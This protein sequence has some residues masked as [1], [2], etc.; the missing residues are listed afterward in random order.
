MPRIAIIIGSTRPNRFGPKVAEWIHGFAQEVSD[1]EFSV[2]DLVDI[3]L[4]L[5]DE[6]N[7]PMQGKY[8]NAHTKA[9]AQ[10]VAGF[11][12]FIFVTPEYN[13]GYPAALKNALD[14]LYAEWNHKPVAFVSYGAGAGG[15]RAVEQLREVVIN[16]LMFPL[17]D[18]VSF[19]NYWTQLDENGDLNANDQQVA[20]AKELVANIA[21]WSDK[22]ATIRSEIASKKS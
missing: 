5:L 14:F 1:A 11:D 10:T 4:P 12:G 21:F 16:L 13:H 2:I 9:W 19:T 22:L 3:Q 20:M 18:H 6:P 8:Q 17:N 15:S 7:P